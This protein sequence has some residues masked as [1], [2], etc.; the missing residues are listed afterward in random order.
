MS[1]LPEETALAT[2]SKNELYELARSLVAI[3]SDPKLGTQAVVAYLQ[4]F[5]A[6]EGLIC[7]VEAVRPPTHLNL[8]VEHSASSG[9]MR[10]LLNGHIDTVPPTDLPQAVRLDEQR[11]SGRGAVDMKGAVAAMSLALV[12]INRA[13][14]SLKHGVMLS[15]VAGEEIG[16]IGT[17]AFLDTG[18]RPEMAVI[19]EPTQLRL[20]AA[21]KGVEWMELQFSGKAGHAS[22][23]EQG[24]NA[25]VAA[26]H[27]VIAL[28]ELASRINTSIRHP[29]LGGAT[30]NIGAIHG[31]TMPNVVP[32]SCT[33]RID[34]RWLPGEEIE[35]IVDD[36][37]Q[38]VQQAARSVPGVHVELI[39]MDETRHNCPMETPISH[40]LVRTM[41]FVLANLG[42]PSDPCGVPFGT[43]APWLA[44]YGIPSIIC[45]PGDIAQA[46]SADEYI[47][48]DQL[49]MSLKVYLSTIQRLCG[50][51]QL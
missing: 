1:D 32:D 4:S 15:A 33:V 44:A 29:L 26:S 46:H 22:C 49:W 14:I 10:L 45:G 6:K 38:I 24:A 3:P 39:R 41:Q 16:G 47:D 20:V 23:P 5:L 51:A 12:A 7:H 43:D 40:P 2:I 50:E 18:R 31:G 17:K 28:N 35:S 30:L 27:A 21:H 48:L 37:S 11:L 8:V 25:I 9:R 13:G 34:R 36:V 19:G 42:L